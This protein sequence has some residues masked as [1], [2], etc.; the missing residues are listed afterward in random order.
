MDFYLL[1]FRDKRDEICNFVE[2]T[3]RILAESNFVVCFLIN[4]TVTLRDLL[5]G[6]SPVTKS[7]YGFYFI[8]PVSLFELGTLPKFHAANIILNI[9]VITMVSYVMQW[10]GR[11]HKRYLWLFH[12]YDFDIFKLLKIHYFSIYDVVDYFPASEFILSAEM[13]SREQL[14]VRSCDLVVAISPK[15][16]DHVSSI[17][18][19]VTLVPQGFR[20]DEFIHP[21]PLPYSLQKQFKELSQKPIIGFVGGINHRIDFALVKGVAQKCLHHNFV[22][23]GPDQTD[24]DKHVGLKV[25]TTAKLVEDLSRLPNVFFLQMSVQ[26]KYIPAILNLFAICMVPYD[27]RQE[28]NQFC[29]PMKIFEYFYSGKPVVSTDIPSLKK[30]SPFV[31]CSNSVR[32]WRE[33]LSRYS[34]VQWPITYIKQQRRIASE[35]SW[36]RKVSRIM[37]LTHIKKRR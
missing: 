36:R 16:V 15:V 4:E 33:I 30:Y 18:P 25:G 26:Q 7:P 9:Y 28:F 31:Q 29:Y 6:V 19:N 22:F 37:R 21:L 34:L 35:N 3:G 20:R 11:I 5:F 17:A 27:T 14:L 13:R 10:C 23:V 12:P 1:I 8:K 2:E 32:G 24:Q